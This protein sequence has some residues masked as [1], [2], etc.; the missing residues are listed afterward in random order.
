MGI[1]IL[2]LD[3]PSGDEHMI[4]AVFVRIEGKVGVLAISE[5]VEYSVGLGGDFRVS[6]F[7]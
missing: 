2:V 6:N 4:G 3:I 1:C 7:L 5:S